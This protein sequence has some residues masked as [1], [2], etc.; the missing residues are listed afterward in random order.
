MI[1]PDNVITISGRLTADANV[2]M[3]GKMLQFSIAVDRAGYEKGSDNNTGFFNCKIWMTENKW[4]SVGFLEMVSELHKSGRLSKGAPVRI[5]GELNQDRYEDNQGNRRTD[6]N[7]LVSD[8]RSYA[9]TSGGNSNN[10]NSAPSESS[11]GSSY[12]EPAEQQASSGP[13]PF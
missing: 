13:R 11:G 12:S 4:T 10:N 5:V 7:I 6:V 8:I 3:D 1:N 9:R 2:V